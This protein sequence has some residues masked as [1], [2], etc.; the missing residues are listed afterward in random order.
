MNLEDMRLI[1]ANERRSQGLQ[2]LGRD[3]YERVRA[4]INGLEDGKRRADDAR[5]AMIDNE[6]Q[7]ARRVI[8]DIFKRRLGKIVKMASTKAFG[9]NIHPEGATQGEQKIFEQLVSSIQEGKSEILG[10]ILQPKEMEKTEKTSKRTESSLLKRTDIK[11]ESTIV[12]VLKDIPTFMGTDGRSY[13]LSEE[14]VVVLP[15]ANAKALCDRR[16]AVIINV[17]K[18]DKNEDA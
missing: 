11:K 15:K 7:S 3:F 16:V 9:L 18:S 14:D 13:Q 17:G 5:V 2:A 1:Q 10:S 6:L 8:D 12:R 4:Y